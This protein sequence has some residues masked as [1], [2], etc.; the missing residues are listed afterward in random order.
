VK[1]IY[2]MKRPGPA[3]KVVL[4]NILYWQVQHPELGKEDLLVAIDANKEEFLAE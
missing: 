3:I 1:Q 4:D 2:S